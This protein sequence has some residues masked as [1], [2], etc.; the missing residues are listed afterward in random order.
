MPERTNMFAK[1]DKLRA[2]LQKAIDKRDEAEEKVRQLEE[3]L[4]QEEATQ[5]VNDVT[6]CNMSP[7]DLNK[8]LAL[9]N[10]G[11]LQAILNGGA[12]T[13]PVATQTANSYNTTEKDD[14]ED[15]EDEDE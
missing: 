14:S 4:K 1:L 8:F 3:K 5:I 15:I 13:T 10:S 2:D 9:V 11:Q 7:E 12:A 6:A